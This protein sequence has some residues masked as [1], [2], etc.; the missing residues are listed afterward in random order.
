V[1]P[2]ASIGDNSVIESSVVT[3]SIIQK[4]AKISA[5]LL[6][7]SMIGNNAEY[8]NHMVQLSIGDFSVQATSS[9]APFTNEKARIE[10]NVPEK[11]LSDTTQAIKAN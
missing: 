8:E 4:N 9:P 10:N 3:N 5:A 11:T 1:G 6:T 2:Y 7:N